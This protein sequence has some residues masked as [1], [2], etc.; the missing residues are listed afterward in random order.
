MNDDVF[1]LQGHEHWQQKA[2]TFHDWRIRSYIDS[3]ILR[4]KTCHGKIITRLGNQTS[5]FQAWQGWQKQTIDCSLCVNSF[6]QPLLI[7]HGTLRFTNQ[8]EH[9][10]SLAGVP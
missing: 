10:G 6:D 7:K 5:D 1:W 8:M 4:I 2:L 9:V 3:D